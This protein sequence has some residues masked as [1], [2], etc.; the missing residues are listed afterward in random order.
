[1]DSQ[2]LPTPAQTPLPSKKKTPLAFGLILG[3]VAIVT[4]V[5]GVVIFNTTKKVDYEE[6]YQLAKDVKSQVSQVAY[7]TDCANVLNFAKSRSPDIEK[8]NSYIQGCETIGEKFAKLQTSV[9]QLGSSTGVKNDSELRAAY[10]DFQNSLRLAVPNTDN[11]K[12]QLRLYQA[13]HEFVMSERALMIAK[14]D[15]SA[16]KAVAQPLLD[17]GNTTLQQYG[18]GWLE[19]TLAYAEAAWTYNN[20][21]GNLN[22]A[23]RRALKQEATNK[24]NEQTEWVKANEPDI[25]ELGGLDFSQLRALG[26][27][28][29]QIYE[30]IKNKYMEGDDSLILLY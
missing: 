6:T 12:Q 2:P 20:S 22:S 3:A 18:E 21:G 27:K 1:M 19:K 15:E 29:D 25:L 23:A 9:E 28:F 7:E 26:S 17:S 14:A 13:W 4:I 30:T 24:N 11:L 8:Y 16:I 10:E 5:T